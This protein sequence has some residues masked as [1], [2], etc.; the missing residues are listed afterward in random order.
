MVLPQP[1]RRPRKGFLLDLPPRRQSPPL[2][3]ATPFSLLIDLQAPPHSSGDS[4]WSHLGPAFL[5]LL[6]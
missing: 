4:D 3:K 5:T 1:Y 2:A 6:R